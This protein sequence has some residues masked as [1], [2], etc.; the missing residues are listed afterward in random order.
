MESHFPVILF[1]IFLPVTNF[2]REISEERTYYS[3]MNSDGCPM[4]TRRNSKHSAGNPQ[5]SHYPDTRPLNHLD[6]SEQPLGY[7]LPQWPE[8]WFAGKNL[9]SGWRSSP[10][11]MKTGEISSGWP[12]ERQDLSF[13]P[14]SVISPASSPNGQ[15]LLDSDQPDFEVLYFGSE[16]HCFEMS[17]KKMLY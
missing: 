3:K 14:S 4:G 6:R 17:S 9:Q 11:W 12:T 7:L 16:V 8:L 15:L 10:K 5:A 2:E 13:Q 1:H